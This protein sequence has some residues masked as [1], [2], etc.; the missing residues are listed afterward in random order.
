MSLDSKVVAG[1]VG[2]IG[3]DRKAGPVMVSSRLTD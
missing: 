3:D 1:R 2:L